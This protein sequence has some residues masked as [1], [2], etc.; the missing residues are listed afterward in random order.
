MKRASV[1]ISVR[2]I[3]ELLLL[4][5]NVRIRHIGSIG[6]EADANVRVE[7]DGDGLPGGFEVEPQYATPKAMLFHSKITNGRDSI[8]VFDR[9]ERLDGVKAK[10]ETV[11]ALETITE[12]LKKIDKNLR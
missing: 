9:I 12:L 2:L 4:P 11:Q 3:E 6:V 10:S 8:T 7:L 1:E 5:A